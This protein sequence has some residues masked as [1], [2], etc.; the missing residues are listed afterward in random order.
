MTLFNV[1]VSYIVYLVI[2]IDSENIC[3]V[4][5]IKTHLVQKSHLADWRKWEPGDYFEEL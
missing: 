5:A 3:S 4:V 1:R 2:S